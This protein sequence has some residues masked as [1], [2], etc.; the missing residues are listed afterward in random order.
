M[1]IVALMLAM[2]WQIHKLKRSGALATERPYL[3]KKYIY[4]SNK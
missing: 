2:L 4:Q 1:V 3:I